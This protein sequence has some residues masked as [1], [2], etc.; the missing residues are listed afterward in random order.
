MFE[1]DLNS[2]I[3]FTDK[4]KKDDAA[5]FIKN[6]VKIQDKFFDML[7]SNGEYTKNEITDLFNSYGL[8]TTDGNENFSLNDLANEKNE[9]ILKILARTYTKEFSN[10]RGLQ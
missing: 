2:H 3:I 5:T 9:F 6:Y 7:A 10:V 8:K 4:D 1:Y